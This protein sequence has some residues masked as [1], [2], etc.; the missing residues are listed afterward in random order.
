[1]GRGGADDYEFGRV[2]DKG[3]GIGARRQEAARQANGGNPMKTVEIETKPDLSACLETAQSGSVLLTRNG[4]PAGLLMNIEGYD[5]ED[6]HWATDAE[7]WRMIEESR[8]QP[9]MSFEELKE[10]LQRHDE[11]Q[12][13][14]EKVL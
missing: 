7:F 1:M 9:T 12:L 8:H 4:K 5:V 13:T 2:C 11:E 3:V 6:L 14:A 10:Y